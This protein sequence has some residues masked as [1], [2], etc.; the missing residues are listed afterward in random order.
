MSDI[1]FHVLESN[2]TV[3]MLFALAGGLSFLVYTF[4]GDDRDSN[5]FR[6]VAPVVL[7][8]IAENIIKA[9]GYVVPQK[10]N[11]LACALC[12]LMIVVMIV[13]SVKKDRSVWAVFN[14]IGNLFVMY[15]VPSVAYLIIVTAVTVG[16]GAIVLIVGIPMMAIM[17]ALAPDRYVYYDR[18]E[19]ER[20]IDKIKRYLR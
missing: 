6:Y 2:R 7:W 14:I 19:V 11:R 3:F 16:G 9:L 8:M 20:S 1:L 12:F 5:T 4:R 17:A 18:D 13:M 10:W 15:A